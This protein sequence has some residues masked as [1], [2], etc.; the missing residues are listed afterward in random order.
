MGE[1]A[2]LTACGS[3]IMESSASVVDEGIE[4]IR[5]AIFGIG[6]MTGVNGGDCSATVELLP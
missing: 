2:A 6:V 3:V 1:E 4:A 5:L